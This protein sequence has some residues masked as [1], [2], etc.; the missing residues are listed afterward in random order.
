V[1]FFNGPAVKRLA[2][3]GKWIKLPHLLEKRERFSCLAHGTPADTNDTWV[4]IAQVDGLV[5]TGHAKNNIQTHKYI[6]SLNK[7][8]DEKAIAAGLYWW[9]RR[10]HIISL[11]GKGIRAVCPPF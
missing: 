1:R 9:L 7:G 6:F 3:R 2:C 5:L 8:G 11:L 10:G 4:R